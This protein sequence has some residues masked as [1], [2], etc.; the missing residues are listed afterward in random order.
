MGG[1]DN[2]PT[3]TSNQQKKNGGISISTYAGGYGEEMDTDFDE[4]FATNDE[5]SINDN[6]T[7]TKNTHKEKKNK[8]KKNNDGML[9]EAIKEYSSSRTKQ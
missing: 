6:D 9:T 4:D 2:K 3:L 1:N 8:K 5:N 7:T